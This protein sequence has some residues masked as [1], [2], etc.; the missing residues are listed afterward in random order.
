MGDV[1]RLVVVEK[2]PRLHTISQLRVA[3]KTVPF[4]FK[5]LSI[6]IYFPLRFSPKVDMLTVS[7]GTTSS[8]WHNKIIQHCQG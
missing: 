1:T 6:F 2:W 3:G 7:D 8:L 4:I 5:C